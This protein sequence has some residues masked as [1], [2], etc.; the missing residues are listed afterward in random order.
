MG[1]GS[2]RRFNNTDVD[3][4]AGSR[5]L[6]ARSTTTW[7]FTSVRGHVV[8]LHMI[9]EGGASASLNLSFSTSPD[10]KQAFQRL[11]RRLK[12]LPQRRQ[13][14][15]AFSAG[16]AST[17]RIAS[18]DLPAPNKM[19]YMRDVNQRR[20]LGTVRQTPE[21][22][23]KDCTRRLLPVPPRA[24]AGKTLRPSRQGQAGF[25]YLSD[26]PADYHARAPMKR[27]ARKTPKR[28]RH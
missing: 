24:R 4:P 22:I 2:W 12:N 7:A 21:Q 13:A 26:N 14:I 20:E 11:T 27:P 28:G 3:V 6:M 9:P 25:T 15:R 8:V 1:A 23:N 5:P 16:G 19:N 10:D 18:H 17:P